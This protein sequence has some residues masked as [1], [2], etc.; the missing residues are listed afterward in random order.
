MCLEK[1]KSCLVRQVLQN[2]STTFRKRGLRPNANIRLLR[3][4]CV[5]KKRFVRFSKRLIVFGRLPT[6][7]VRLNHRKTRPRWDFYLC[8]A[9]KVYWLFDGKI[10][11]N[12]LHSAQSQTFQVCSFAQCSSSL[13]FARQIACA[14]PIFLFRKTLWCLKCAK[15]WHS[16]RQNTAQSLLCSVTGHAVLCCKKQTTY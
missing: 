8:L 1:S 13:Y 2:A 7:F 12:L 14:K 6:C 3:L 9:Q 15:W 4:P 16:E 5:V 10:L 11:C